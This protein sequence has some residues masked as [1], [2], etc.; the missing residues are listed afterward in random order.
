MDTLYVESMRWFVWALAVFFFF[1]EYLLRIIPSVLEKE[2]V[3]FYHIGA[4]TFGILSSFYFFAYAPMQIPAGFLMDRFGARK[5]LT[6]AVGICGLG[7]LLFGL[8]ESF[9]FETIA[10]FLMGFGSAF[11][12]VGLVYVSSHLFEAKR[13][14]LL[15]GIGNSFGMLGGAAEGPL[16]YAVFYFGWKETVIGIG[17]LGFVLMAVMYISILKIETLKKPDASE[18]HFWAR[19]HCNLKLIG[20]NPYTWVNA[21]CAAFFLATTV[22][23]SGLWG[24]SFLKD[25][26][27]I[28]TR[29]ASTSTSMFFLG[30]IV[31]GPIICFY[32]DKIQ[33]R[34][35]MLL[36]FTFVGALTMSTLVF[37]QS[38][39]PFSWTFFLHFI[40]GLASSAQLLNYCVAIE[41]NP[42]I[43]KGAAASTTNFVVYFCGALIQPLVGYLIQYKAGHSQIFTLSDY[44]FALA[45]FPISFVLA[46]ILALFLKEKPFNEK[47]LKSIER[48]ICNT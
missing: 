12:F 13:L 39:I 40:L 28:T 4:S 27:S 22:A 2:L 42:D 16:G 32:S 18:G 23:Y 41:I 47:H 8:G 25:T 36:I 3:E 26:Y 7:G 46:F 31:G 15:I 29:L 10:R 9:W 19:L 14:A 44:Q 21:C 24:V 38:Y 35:I 37:F 11:A 34:K 45:I 6:I 1:Y 17:A 20:R 33:N 48:D 30:Y 43:T 5:L